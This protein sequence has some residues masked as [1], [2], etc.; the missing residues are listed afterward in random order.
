MPEQAAYFRGPFLSRKS[1]TRPPANRLRTGERGELVI[2][3]ITKEGTPLIRYRTR[4]ITFLD[5]SPCPCGRTSVRMNR[6]LGRTDDMLII[7][8]VNVFP[9]ADR[10]GAPALR[11]Y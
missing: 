5:R 8:G 7:R 3:T 1:S 9:V 4:D 6:L 11:R 2:T 10:G